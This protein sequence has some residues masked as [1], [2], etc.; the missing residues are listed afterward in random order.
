MISALIPLAAA[1]LARSA[2]AQSDS[3]TPPYNA[4]A[5]NPWWPQYPDGRSAADY[6]L[7]DNASEADLTGQSDVAK[8][9]IEASNMWR[10]QF[11]E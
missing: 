2:V 4:S 7:S 8:W 5:T 10:A 1:V 3:N 9:L 11:G 6:M